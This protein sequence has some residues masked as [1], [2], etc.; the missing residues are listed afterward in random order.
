MAFY[1]EITPSGSTEY[2]KGKWK[3]VYDKFMDVK[4]ET[5]DSS[6]HIDG[7]CVSISAD[8]RTWNCYLGQGAVDH[9]IIG[10]DLLGQYLPEPA[11]G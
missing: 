10:A 8:G 11:S 2:A 3:R 7:G 1:E 6:K 4:I 9:G 5:V